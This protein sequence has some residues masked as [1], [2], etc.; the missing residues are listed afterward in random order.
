MVWD[1]SAADCSSFEANPI[2]CTGKRSRNNK[3]VHCRNNCGDTIHMQTTDKYTVTNGRLI[4]TL[5]SVSL[6]DIVV[7]TSM[8]NDTG[9]PTAS[10]PPTVQ[11]LRTSLRTA[12]IAPIALSG[13]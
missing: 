11:F 8:R 13:E 6:I 1:D 2:W 9:K 7:F 10:A 3:K 4:I 12:W 5:Q